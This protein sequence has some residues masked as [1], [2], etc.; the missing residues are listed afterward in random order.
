[1]IA[2]EVSDA[3]A[4]YH[5]L[6]DKNRPLAEESAAMLTEKQPAARTMFGGKP[7]CTVLRPQFLSP[8]TYA[9][10]QEVCTVL[11]GAMFRLAERI[12][13]D[14][15]LVD[16]LGLT[17]T[18]QELV[19]VD[20]GY[21]EISPTSRLDSFMS[22]DSWQF[23]E[24]NAETPAAVAYEDVLSE[25][26]LDLPV[27]RAFTQDFR[28][29]ALPAMHR[30]RDV[31]L[32]AYRQWGGQGSPSI[33][34]VDWKG[35]PTEPEFEL[36]AEYFRQSGLT[37]IIAEPGRLEYDGTR[38]RVEGQTIDLV[39]KRVLISELLSRPEVAR[40][41]V[42]AYKNH[43]VCMVNSFRS[44][45]LHKKAIFALLS[46]ERYAAFFDEREC[47]AIAEHV[48]WTRRVAERRTTCGGREIELVPYVR[49]HRE[50]LLLKPN[51]EYGGKGV[52]IGWEVSQAEWEA[53]L[54]DALREPY[55]VQD[56]VYVG[57]EAFPRW[58]DTDL[59]W[60]DLAADLDPFL[61]HREVGGVLTRL[62]PA[63]LLNVTA[64]AGSTVPTFL[65]ER[66]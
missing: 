57:C 7:L 24:Y 43:H 14:P 2:A 10:I 63:A 65:V 39:Y 42:E 66:A 33:A 59:I 38:L 11:S 32:D 50:H 22:R 27:M 13:D 61:F 49:D 53:A 60:V 40:P 58:S 34:I 8:Q 9:R 3:T 44:K 6:L 48:P 30:L 17:P 45:L 28:V 16:L 41:L 56:R 4:A 37:A 23:V 5:D 62:S 46:D 15:E 31:L 19:A 26:F 25:L 20:P 21:R 18:E 36:F 35:V 12:P 1:M 52:V 51:D 55:V 64:G 47:E 29:T 54:T